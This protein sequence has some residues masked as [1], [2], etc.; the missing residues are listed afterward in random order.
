MSHI[1]AMDL[2]IESLDALEEACSLLGLQLARDQKT[3]RWW[4]RFV[5]DS[6]APKGVKISDLGKCLHAIKIPDN[7]NAY[8][9]GVIRAEAGGFQLLY[10]FYGAAG[11]AMQKKVGET[12]GLLKQAYAIARAKK[13][14]QRKG[15][16]TLLKKKQNGNMLL[17]VY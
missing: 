11:Q 13:E 5:G 7:K 3:Y 4:G 8:E 16:R 14:A 15:M 12:G 17:E 6:P 2:S 1:V 10:D 9:I